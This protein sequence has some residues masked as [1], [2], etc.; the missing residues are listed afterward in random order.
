ML[1][2]AA[3]W[4]A[5][6]LRSGNVQV[7]DRYNPWA[8]L[9]VAA[10]PDLL[11]GFK[12]AR[13]RADPTRCLAALAT[14]GMAYEPV[15]DRG[16]GA[17]CGFSNAVRLRDAGVRIGAPLLLSCPVALSFNLWERHVVQPAA[18]RHFGQRVATLQHFG[19]YACRN[20]NTGEGSRIG[21][22]DQP[23][24]RSRHATADAIDVAGFTLQDGRRIT[25][26]Q[27]WKAG[28]GP[29]GGMKG[30]DAE[31]AWLHEVH[32]GA[33]RFFTGVLGPAYNAVHRDHFHF[34]TGGYSMCR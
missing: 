28:S 9:D 34:E 33:C 10:E 12:L 6:A 22:A 13:A 7:P 25:V 5:W 24:N 31:A 23:G 11:T 30:P 14:T 4:L 20:V 26:L 21:G 32:E 3:G 2:G 8:P 17:G 27:D 18:E 1:L 15:A 29:P 19:S 16:T